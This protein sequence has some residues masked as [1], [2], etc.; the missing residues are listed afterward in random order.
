MEKLLLIFNNRSSTVHEEAML[1]VG[2]FSYALGKQFTKYLGAF[3]PY[4]RV[5]LTNYQEWQVRGV[6]SHSNQQ[7]VTRYPSC[8][9]RCHS[10]TSAS[11][12]ADL[13]PLG[14]CLCRC[15]NLCV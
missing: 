15:S 1:A 9:N 10:M 12:H 8:T 2:A 14:H 5:G 13:G 7:T 11:L 6:A 4:L 3:F